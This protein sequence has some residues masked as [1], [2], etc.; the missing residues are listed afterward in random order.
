MKVNGMFAMFAR[1]GRRFPMT[2]NLSDPERELALSYAAQPLRGH[3]RTLWTLDERFGALV[4]GTSEA[5]LG[6]M[7]L[8]WWREAIATSDEGAK[9]EPLLEQVADSIRATRSDPSEWGAMAEGWHALLQEPLASAELDRFALERGGR[10][11]R[12]SAALL[13]EGSR[14]NDTVE[15]AGRGWAL[16]DLSFRHSDEGVALQARKQGMALLSDVGIRNWPR[17][18]QSLGALT[19]LAQRDARNSGPVRRQ[20]A[21]RRIA[22][23]LA[24]RIFGR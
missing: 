3:L 2:D 5:T 14:E 1:L 15:Q 13:G 9:T 8:L 19:L 23:L 18:L 20:G 11:F 6:E 12:L 24:Y 22:R 17:S 16:V 21:P 10:L 7:R 4:A